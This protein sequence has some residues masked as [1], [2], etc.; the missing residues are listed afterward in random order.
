MGLWRNRLVMTAEYY[1][2]RTRNMLYLYDV[3]VPPFPYEKMLANLGKMSN[4]GFELGLGVTPIETRDLQLNL[5][6]NLSYQR[7]KLISLSGEYKGQ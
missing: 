4:S 1:Y 6:M 5:N 7:N 2:S 3:S